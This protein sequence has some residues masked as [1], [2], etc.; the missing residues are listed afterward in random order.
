MSIE[1]IKTYTTTQNL[2]GTTKVI[3]VPMYRCKKCE[4]IKPKLNEIKKHKC[5]PK[6]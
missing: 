4:L 6:D 1:Q 3:E 5:N 2:N